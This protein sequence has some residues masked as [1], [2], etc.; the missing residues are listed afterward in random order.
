MEKFNIG[1]GV[2]IVNLLNEE[3]KKYLKLERLNE[4]LDYLYTQLVEQ[5]YIDNGDVSINFNVNFNDIERTVLYNNNV[6]EL[7]GDTIYLKCD[8]I[9]DEVLNQYKPNS[10][11]T[12]VIKKFVNAA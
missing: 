6:F 9:P 12:D 2:V 1:A 4:L 10:F 11:I 8:A 5:G 3:R 7:I